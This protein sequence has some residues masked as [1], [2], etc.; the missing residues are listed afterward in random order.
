MV[1]GDNIQTATAIALEC[2]ILD[3]KELQPGAIIEGRAFR[4]LSENERQRIARDLSVWCHFIPSNFY[5]MSFG[6]LAG[7]CLTSGDGKILT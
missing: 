3:P 5:R 4:V 7:F 2:G 1:T 6:F